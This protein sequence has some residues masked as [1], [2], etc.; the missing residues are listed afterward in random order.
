MALFMYDIVCPFAY[1]ASRLIESIEK[2][3]NTKIYWEPVILGLY[4]QFDKKQ[5]NGRRITNI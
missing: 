1:I 4:N 3:C 2:E 5:K